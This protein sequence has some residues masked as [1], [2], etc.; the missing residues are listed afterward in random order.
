MALRS[1]HTSD[2]IRDAEIAV[3]QRD[4]TLVLNELFSRDESI[5]LAS[6]RSFG[7]LSTL[8][9]LGERDRVERIRM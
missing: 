2:Y 4:M 7:S 5:R 3:L 6:L 8:G 1:S 9:G